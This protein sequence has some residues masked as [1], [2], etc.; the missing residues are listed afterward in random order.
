M[1]GQQP[2]D[3]PWSCYINECMPKWRRKEWVCE[4][5]T[6]EGLQIMGSSPFKSWFDCS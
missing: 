6:K 5:A 3:I 4:G 1:D 2:S